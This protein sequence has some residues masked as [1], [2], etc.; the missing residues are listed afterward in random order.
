MRSVAHHGIATLAAD[1]TAKQ[2]LLHW[3]SK[4]L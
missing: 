1:K 2:K 4:Q 3:L